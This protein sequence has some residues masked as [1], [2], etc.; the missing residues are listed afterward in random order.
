MSE[1]NKTSTSDASSTEVNS[2]GIPARKRK[3]NS[4]IFGDDYVQ[5]K[6]KSDGKSSQKSNNNLKN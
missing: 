2:R 3:P 1:S 5:G 4:L 6:T